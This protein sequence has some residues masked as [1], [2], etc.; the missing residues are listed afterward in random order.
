MNLS[1][2]SHG[3][4]SL[5]NLIDL[6]MKFFDTLVINS[7]NFLLLIFQLFLLVLK[8]IIEMLQKLFLA[9]SMLK[10]IFNFMIFFLENFG[11]VFQKLFFTSSVFKSLLDT[12]FISLENFLK[13]L[14]K[15]FLTSCVF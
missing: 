15:L 3:L 14:Q 9:S 8:D 13:I 12:L 7:I 6:R 11:K 4:Y 2:A 5:D 1:P 10:S